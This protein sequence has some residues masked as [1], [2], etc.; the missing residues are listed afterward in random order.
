MERFLSGQLV[1]RTTQACC[2]IYNKAKDF[3][4]IVVFPG[5]SDIAALMP[6]PI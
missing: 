2:P 4:L 6:T 3:A 5:I 1:V